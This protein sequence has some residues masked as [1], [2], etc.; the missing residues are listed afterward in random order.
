MSS[1][2]AGEDGEPS[3]IRGRAFLAAT[4]IVNGTP[5]NDTITTYSLGEPINGLAGNDTISSLGGD[6]IVRGGAGADRLLG[7][8]GNG[9]LLGGAGK[10]NLKGE[11]DN[12]FLVGGAARDV[13]VGGL[14]TDR[15]DFNK[16][17]ESTAG[18]NRDVVK[19]FNHS[20]HDKI[21]LKTIDADTTAGGNQAFDLIGGAAAFS[22]VA[23]ELRFAAGLLQG[24]STATP[25]PISRS[26]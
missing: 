22:G 8:V 15:F 26:I 10:D 14:G 9:R 7:G 2:G 23:G 20:E 11:D 16:T 17:G 6:D 1:P 3:G 21:D 25:S 13:L 4:E 12:D 24:M 5:G 18:A 19:G